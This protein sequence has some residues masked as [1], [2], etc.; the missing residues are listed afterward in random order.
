MEFLASLQAAVINPQQSVRVSEVF[1][2]EDRNVMVLSRLAHSGFSWFSRLEEPVGDDPARGE[3]DDS[4]NLAPS[5]QYNLPAQGQ[6]RRFR[7]TPQPQPRLMGPII[8]SRAST[9]ITHSASVHSS[10]ARTTICITQSAK[11]TNR[12]KPV[13]FL[14]EVI[15]WLCHFDGSFAANLA[16]AG[17]ANALL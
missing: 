3:R 1:L 13:A 8:L 7:G 14:I 5:P 2:I 15:R 12:V 11:I 6:Q 4:C 17:S 9:T 10:V 16:L